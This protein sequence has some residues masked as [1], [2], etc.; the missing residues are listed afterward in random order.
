MRYI[1]KN[2]FEKYVNPEEVFP[3]LGYTVHVANSCRRS[4]HN[5]YCFGLVGTRV[6]YAGYPVGICCGISD[7]SRDCQRTSPNSREQTVLWDTEVLVR[8]L[9]SVVTTETLLRLQYLPQEP[10][11][12]RSRH[13]SVP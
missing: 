9:Y 2:G 1:V 13:G 11:V 7:R 4:Q 12:T 3:P 5:I 6:L 8:R 10:L